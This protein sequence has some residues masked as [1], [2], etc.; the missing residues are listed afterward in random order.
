MFS[1]LERQQLLKPLT[2]C[3]LFAS[4]LKTNFLKCA[5]PNSSILYSA[6]Y[7][8]TETKGVSEI[9][10]VLFKLNMM[11]LWQNIFSTPVV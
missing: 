7:A 10:T 9:L 2:R 6:K 4:W 1:V 5:I 11:N 8:N 3:I